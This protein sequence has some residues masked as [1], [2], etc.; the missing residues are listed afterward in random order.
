[1][2]DYTNMRIKRKEAKEANLTF[3][4]TFMILIFTIP[5]F[6]GYLPIII[7]EK[8]S[9]IFSYLIIFIIAFPLV[10]PNKTKQIHSKQASVFQL[11]SRGGKK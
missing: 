10:L 8:T 3:I 4:N 11:K 2:N 5:V 1:M 6:I 9:V 7:S